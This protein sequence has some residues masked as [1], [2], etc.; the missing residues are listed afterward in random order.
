MNFGER[1]ALPPEKGQIADLRGLDPTLIPGSGV[2][3]KANTV[4]SE[5]HRR[6]HWLLGSLCWAV[7]LNKVS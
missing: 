5:A 2:G 1:S 6:G 3:M 7:L 4:A